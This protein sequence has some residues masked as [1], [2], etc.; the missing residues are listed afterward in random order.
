MGTSEPAPVLEAGDKGGGV[1]L[2]EADRDLRLVLA[3][4]LEREG[5]TVVQARDSREALSRAIAGQPRC[6]VL[7]LPLP[8]G[9]PG[10]ILRSLRGLAGLE[11]VPA[12]VIAPSD[13]RL[14]EADGFLEARD[15]RLPPTFGPADFLGSVRRAA[16]RPAMVKASVE[17]D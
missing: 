17:E 9:E 2:C 3:A 15:E 16:A 13:L 1:L 6:V 11:G 5:E 10:D 12:V 7:S 4:L 14:E 8:G